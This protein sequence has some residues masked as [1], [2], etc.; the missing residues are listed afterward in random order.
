[1]KAARA[2]TEGPVDVASIM[3]VLAQIHEHIIWSEKTIRSAVSTQL[4]HSMRLTKNVA[5]HSTM[6]N[7]LWSEHVGQ[8]SSPGLQEGP[9]SRE[10]VCPSKRKGYSSSGVEMVASMAK[11]GRHLCREEQIKRKLEFPIGF[12]CDVEVPAN[13]IEFSTPHPSGR[14]RGGL[15][16]GED[17]PQ[18]FDLVFRPPEGMFFSNLELAVVAYVFDAGLDKR[19]VLFP[20]EHTQ[21]DRHAFCTLCPGEELIDDVI[22]LLATVLTDE[23]SEP[24]WWLSTSFAMSSISLNFL[25]H[26]IAL[27]PGN[28]CSKTLE[29]IKRRFMSP[30][31]DITK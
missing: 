14:N 15:L 7:I 19:E 9:K 28:Y 16:Q 11:D 18:V 2:T 23:R 4:Q 22:N 6:L 30:M 21:G 13:S 12:N 31:D 5:G 17:M 20:S 27:S 25:G 8:K 26:Q 1:E 29:F 3:D 24:S 10:G